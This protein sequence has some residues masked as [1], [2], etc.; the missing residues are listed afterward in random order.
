M[1]SLN[2]FWWTIFIELTPP[3]V[4]HTY[5]K[6]IMYVHSAQQEIAFF[7]SPPCFA[8]H[9]L[10][11]NSFW[12]LIY[13]RVII[14]FDLVLS[15]DFFFAAQCETRFVKEGLFVVDEAKFKSAMTK[16]MLPHSVA[17]WVHIGLKIS[18]FVQYCVVSGIPKLHLRSKCL[19]RLACSW[20]KMPMF[21]MA[22]IQHF[23]I[24]FL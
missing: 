24:W 16:Q 19:V 8:L 3:N 6:H 12:W 15:P 17:A 23:N 14:N 22:G 4:Q 1:L 9:M 20:S 10:S 13:G 2:S 18:N 21:Q 5:L 7:C 11:L